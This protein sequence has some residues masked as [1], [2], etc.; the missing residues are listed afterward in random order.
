MRG[1]IAGRGPNSRVEEIAAHPL[2][3]ARLDNGPCPMV[4]CS[5]FEGENGGRVDK[6]HRFSTSGELS[7]R[8]KTIR[9]TL[10]RDI[11][12]RTGSNEIGERPV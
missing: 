9:E 1:I 5:V 2:P 3:K 12:A 6:E 10:V 4:P 8:P 11:D 7:K